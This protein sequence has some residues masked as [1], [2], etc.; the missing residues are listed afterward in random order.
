[1]TS[2]EL[3]VQSFT[4]RCMVWRK[5]FPLISN[6]Q[7]V[8]SLFHGVV[9]LY[10]KKNPLGACQRA[11]RLLN[12]I[13]APGAIAFAR[14]LFELGLRLFGVVT[15]SYTYLYGG[16]ASGIASVTHFVWGVARASLWFNHSTHLQDTNVLSGCLLNPPGGT[17]TKAPATIQ[18]RPGTLASFFGMP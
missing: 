12:P 8:C 1:M 13:S 14:H 4:Y 11:S 7:A 3:I 10:I 9:P 6:N 5:W 18:D 17:K 15:S 16:F 2:Q